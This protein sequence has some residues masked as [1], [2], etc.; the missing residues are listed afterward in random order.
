MDPNDHLILQNFEFPEQDKNFESLEQAV[1]YAIQK[2]N[3]QFEE[4]KK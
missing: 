4:I 2:L 1:D 3:I